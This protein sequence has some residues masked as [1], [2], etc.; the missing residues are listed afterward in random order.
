MDNKRLI[1]TKNLTAYENMAIDEALLESVISNGSQAIL[2]FYTWKRPT[3]SIGYF[4]KLEKEIN[5]NKCREYSVDYVRR[6]TGGRAV[7]HDDE[8]TY[9]FIFKLT[10]KFKKLS[11]LEIFKKI[12]QTFLKGL[13]SLG[14][15]AEL[16]PRDHSKKQK[17]SKA[18]CFTASAFFE[19]KVNGKK[20]L[21]SA[22]TRKSETILQHGSLPI[23]LD[24]QKL[25][26]LFN[27]DS[28]LEKRAELEKSYSLMTSLE[29]I[30]GKRIEFDK[31]CEVFTAGFKKIWGRDFETSS[32]SKTEK[33][34]AG[35][36]LKEKYKTVEWNFLR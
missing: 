32:L 36:L 9:S 30:L 31:L 5:L 6:P 7:L 22:Q 23:S 2:R 35:R 3:I 19:L 20:I 13:K 17:L 16:V 27:F 24:R 8:L 28:D 14:I 10:D 11:T 29:E 26:D 33:E 34:L 18:V 4:Q 12:N 1:I 21:G 25:F 15:S